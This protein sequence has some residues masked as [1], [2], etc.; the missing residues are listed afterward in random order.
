MRSFDRI[1]GIGECFSQHTVIYAFYKWGEIPNIPYLSGLKA[2]FFLHPSTVDHICM[3]MQMWVWKVSIPIF[4]CFD[5]PGSLV[6]KPGINQVSR[7]VIEFAPVLIGLCL[8]H[9]FYLTHGF[10]YRFFMRAKNFFIAC[11]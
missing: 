6:R 7:S 1:S 2:L 3:L 5:W 11:K 4:G 10:L 9:I 8:H